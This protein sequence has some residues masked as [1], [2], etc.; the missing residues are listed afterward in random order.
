MRSPYFVR[1]TLPRTL[2]E[3]RVL[4]I[5]QFGKVIYVLQTNHQLQVAFL[6]EEYIAQEYS[7]NIF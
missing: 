5:M 2:L 4:S 7:H 3:F 1:I 6:D